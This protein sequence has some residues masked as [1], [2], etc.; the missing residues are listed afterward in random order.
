MKSYVE[1]YKKSAFLLDIRWKLH[2]KL[3]QPYFCNKILE[4]FV[5][6]FCAIANKT[7][8][9]KEINNNEKINVT[10][11]VNNYVLSILQGKLISN[12]KYKSSYL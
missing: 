6:T 11:Y 5:S 2:R 3:I 10:K 4:Q 9:N 1:F 7:F 8:I 12:N